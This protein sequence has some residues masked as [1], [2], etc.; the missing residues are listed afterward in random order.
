LFKYFFGFGVV[1]GFRSNSGLRRG[2]G[3]RFQKPKHQKSKAKPKGQKNKPNQKYVEETPVP[4]AQEIVDSTLNRLNRLSIQT[5]A[6]SPFSQYFDD[7]LVNLR[8]VVAEFESNPAITVDEAFVNAR[9]QVFAD[10]ERQFA[11]LRLKESETDASIR[12]LADA[13]HLLVDLDAEYTRQNRAFEEKRNGEIEHL[14]KNVHDYE[15]ELTGI[16]QTKTSFLNPFAKKAKTQKQFEATQKLNAAKNELEIV[17]QSFKVEQEKLHD[18][19]EKKKQDVIQKVQALENSIATTEADTS[20]DAR[21]TTCN[22]LANA[23]KELFE[24]QKTAS[25]PQPT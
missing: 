11:E 18:E 4:S 15:E 25:T 22:A 20:L 9:L 1:M 12:A 8:E 16:E 7:W 14:S 21:Q 13:N 10:V 19:Y 17:V 23:T 6:L 24:R 2:V 5:F 3:Q